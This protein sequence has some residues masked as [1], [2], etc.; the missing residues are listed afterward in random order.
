MRRFTEILRFFDPGYTRFHEEE[1]LGEGALLA[2][3]AAGVRWSRLLT[4]RL[5]SPGRTAAR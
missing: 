1:R 4:E 3:Q 5:A 2:A